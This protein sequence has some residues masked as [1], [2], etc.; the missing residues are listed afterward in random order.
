MAVPGINRRRFLVA[1]VAFHGTAGALR[2]SA[3][4]AQAPL[5]DAARTTLV[6]LARRL[7]PHAAMPD[8]V[9]ADVLD[10]ALTAVANDNSLR[11]AFDEADAALNAQQAADFTQLEADAQ[12][13]TMRSIDG[14]PY[15]AAI[16]NAVLVGVYNHPAVWSMLGY[17][18]PSFERGGYINRGAG[19]IDWLPEV[20]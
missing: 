8:T 2:F 7:Y 15:F 16:Q 13:A 18:G 11:S 5:D 19:E 17:E 6:Q 14:T 10:S 4:W 1:A 9:Y 20:D 3:A 12:V